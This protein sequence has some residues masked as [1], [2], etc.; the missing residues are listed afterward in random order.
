M[1]WFPT[2]PHLYFW[3]PTAPMAGWD[4]CNM[5]LA[6]GSGLEQA[7][8]D[9]DA[10]MPPEGLPVASERAGGESRRL[11]LAREITRS[12]AEGFALLTARTASARYAADFLSTVGNVSFSHKILNY[13]NIPKIIFKNLKLSQK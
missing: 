8:V 2:V 3:L 1:L 13:L 4:I 9:A 6:G 10:A 11:G 5:C 12:A 7:F